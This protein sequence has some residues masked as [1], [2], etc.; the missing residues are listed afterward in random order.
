MTLTYIDFND[1]KKLINYQ[2]SVQSLNSVY[3]DLSRTVDVQ[4][5]N[6]IIE[7]LKPLLGKKYIDYQTFKKDLSLQ[8]GEDAKK[9]RVQITKYSTVNFKNQIALLNGFVYEKE[10]NKSINLSEFKKII[11]EDTSVIVSPEQFNFDIY[12][13][14]I[15][16]LKQDTLQITSFKQSEISGK[17]SLQKTKMLFFTIPFDK[18]WHIKVDGKNETLQR[19]NIGFTGIVLP[20]GNHKIKLYYI[21]QYDKLTNGISLFAV[22]IFWLYSGFYFYKKRKAKTLTGHD[23]NKLKE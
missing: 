4:K 5:L 6:V 22:L 8:L 20:K 18:G 3:Q 15:D 11:P 7:K 16:S 21:P 9:Y 10:F 14:I 13:R 12:K 2:I 19:I 17:I 23:N 1:F